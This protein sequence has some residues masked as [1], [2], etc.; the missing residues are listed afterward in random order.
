[1]SG[2]IDTYFTVKEPISNELV[3]KGSRFIGTAIPVR[4]KD[5]ALQCLSDIRS[6]FYDA[7]H[8]CY[9]YRLGRNGFDF[10]FSDDGEP[11]GTAGKPILFM[12]QKYEFSDVLVVVTRYF[13]G[14]KLG[15]GGLSRAYS[16]TAEELLK[17]CVREPVFC[18]KT[19]KVLCTYEDVNTVK[20]V[21]EK[22]A[23]AVD[24]DYRDVI[25]FLC[26]IPENSV[27]EFCNEIL[28]KTHARAGTFVSDEE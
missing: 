9:A 4:S 3:I 17:L 1:M 15:V 16:D 7:T 28:G 12:I 10:R 18:T 11:N 23:V 19:V 25:E 5:E 26:K 14:T 2:K 20:T 13:G 8:N 27:A 24:S 21:V 22:H 6:K